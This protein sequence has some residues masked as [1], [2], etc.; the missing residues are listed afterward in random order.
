MIDLAV[1]EAEHNGR[2][3]E[4][5]FEAYGL[6]MAVSASRPELLDRIRQVLPPGWQS[7]PPT[8]IASRF[9]LTANDKGTFVLERD[10]DPLSGL[11][12]IDLDLALELLETQLRLLLALRAPD[13]IFIHAGVVGHKGM[14]IVMP[15]SSFAGKTS[16][17]AALVREG[18]EYYS[19]EFAVIDRDGLVH[20]YAKPLSIRDEVS[21]M[22][23]DHA[24]ESLGGVAGDNPLP[25]GMIVITRYE[26]AAEWKP[27]RL[28][29][30]AGAM[31]LL[32]HAGPAQERPQE[33]LEAISRVAKDAVI[34]ESE[35]DEADQ[36]APLLL[37]E[38]ERH[39]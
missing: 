10:G 2:P 16:L 27:K 5:A 3:N 7:C 39:G 20:P 31:A 29:A 30:G 19:D 6:R 21:R 35:R 11:Q 18:A 23:N 38:L 37:A 4:V 32:A 15:G 34:L 9:S 13:T 8:G 33:V 14:A 17:V 36:I 25:V 12:S 22:Q 24:V 26:P 28:S 1:G